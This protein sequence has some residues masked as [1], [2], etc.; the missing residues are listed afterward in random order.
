MNKIAHGLYESARA[1][2]KFQQLNAHD[3]GMN[4]RRVV[5]LDEAHPE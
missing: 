1:I 5:I 2:G 4:K 3:I